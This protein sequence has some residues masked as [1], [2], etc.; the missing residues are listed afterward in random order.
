[1]D[2]AQTLEVHQ[3]GDFALVRWLFINNHSLFAMKE[4]TRQPT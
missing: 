2:Q 3:R 4:V 1:M